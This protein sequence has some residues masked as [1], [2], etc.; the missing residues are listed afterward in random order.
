ME[1]I[2]KLILCKCH[3]KRLTR[4]YCATICSLIF[5]IKVPKVTH[6]H[7]RQLRDDWPASEL[8]CVLTEIQT[9]RN[10]AS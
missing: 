2:T 1:V 5:R 7:L 9:S 4:R 6:A 8:I 3:K 10:G